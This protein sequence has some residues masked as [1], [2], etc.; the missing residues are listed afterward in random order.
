MSDNKKNSSNYEDSETEKYD[1]TEDEMEENETENE[2]EN[3]ENGEI[4]EEE[5]IMNNFKPKTRKEIIVLAP[6]NRRTS[7][8]MTKAELA[9]IKAMSAMRM[10][11]GGQP[12]VD[13]GNLSKYEDIAIK[14]IKEKKCP[15]SIVRE[16]TD[17]IVEVWEVNEMT[18]P[19]DM[20]IKK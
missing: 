5:N 3:E 17:N 8:V 13:A 18:L 19:L 16:L 20:N 15:Y 1:I 9:C 6:E 10:E 12:F 7:E 2:A 11:K 4:E 14:E